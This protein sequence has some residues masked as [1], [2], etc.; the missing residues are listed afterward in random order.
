[1]TELEDKPLG[2][3]LTRVA[4]ALRSEVV[5]TVLKAEELTFP[6]YLCLR[7]LSEWPATP[8]AALA[9]TAGISAQAMN[10]VVR[11]L[12]DRDLVTRPATVSSG[13]SRPATLTRAG[14]ATLTRMDPEVLAAERR[15]LGA[16]DE[17]DQREFRRLLAALG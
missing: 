1:M 8:N 17:S 5:A 7:M 11:E 15:V 14:V 6:E 3:L 9:R 12:Q 16:L 4:T 2:Y 10:K 13:R